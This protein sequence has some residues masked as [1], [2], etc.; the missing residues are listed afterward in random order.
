MKKVVILFLLF[1]SAVLYGFLW[2]PRQKEKLCIDFPKVICDMDV[3][4]EEKEKTQSNQKADED[5][6][7]RVLIKDSSY[8]AIYHEML[9]FSC[10]T[11]ILMVTERGTKLLSQNEI[12]YLKPS[13]CQENPVRL[14]P[15]KQGNMRFYNIQRKDEVTYQGNFEC[16][17]E[18]EGLV[19]VNELP[20][21]S[22]L[23]GVVVSEMPS[24]YPLEALKA[25]AIVARSY[26][27][28]HMEQKAYPQYRADVDDS[29][30]FQVYQNVTA[31]AKTNQAVEE[32]KEQVLIEAGMVQECMYYS[33]SAGTCPDKEK[34]FQKYIRNGSE[35]DLEYEEGWY[36]WNCEVTV[37]WKTLR[38][39][40]LGQTSLT[41][42][43]RV[44]CQ[45]AKKLK[46]VTISQRNENGRVE[47]IELKT[48]AGKIL[49]TDQYRIRGLLAQNGSMV[50]KKDGTTFLMGTILPSP[51]FY[52]ANVTIKNGEI[53]LSIMGGGFG[54]GSGM[55]QNGAKQLA[56]KG[57]GYQEILD[58]YYDFKI[59]KR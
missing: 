50:Y 48:D 36:R 8:E 59:S 7:I 37:S 11:D 18:K 2:Y 13:D 47:E 39:R 58:Y 57:K 15:C 3:R 56:I 33:T 41:E 54:H 29:T 12:Y 34:S 4:L 14:V 27:Y 26:A 25:Q 23:L 55:S 46:K 5:K 20:V 32:T 16:F 49:V 40:L 6:N 52:F 17:G 22:Y 21:E 30:G 10:D 45:K 43:E 28:Y 44:I 42:K 51:F 1:I 24:S 9:C 31:T 38:D 19:L 35:K 53:G